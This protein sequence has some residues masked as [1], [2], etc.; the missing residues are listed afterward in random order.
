M[1]VREAKLARIKEDGEN[2]VTTSSVDNTKS[3]VNSPITD[4]DIPF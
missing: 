2:G 4:D 1:N 3:K